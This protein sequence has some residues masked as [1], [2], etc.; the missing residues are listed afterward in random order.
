MLSRRSFAL[1]LLSLG[2]TRRLLADAAPALSL[3]ATKTH[4]DFKRGKELLTRYVIDEKAA[5]P[6]F[7]PINLAGSAVTRSWPM[8]DG[9]GEA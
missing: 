4:V 8:D 9:K 1:G 2:V 3:E 6:Y 5:K 7:W